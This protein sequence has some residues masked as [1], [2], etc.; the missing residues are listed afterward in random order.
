MYG[1][2]LM[3]GSLSSIPRYSALRSHYWN[4][5]EGVEID[6][7]SEQFPDISYKDLSGEV[8]TRDSVL[9]HPDTVRRYKL[10][11]SRLDKD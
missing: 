2:E 9:D 5:I 1:G 7:T 4:K 10:L 3:R 8:R 11:K 6:F